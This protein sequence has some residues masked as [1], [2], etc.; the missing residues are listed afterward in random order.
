MRSAIFSLLLVCAACITVRP[1]DNH[2]WSQQYGARTS[3]LAGS[4]VAGV[5]DNSA[6]YYNPGAAG[7]IGGN[8]LSVNA[9]TYGYLHYTIDNGAGDGLN[10]KY[11]GIGFYPQLLSG[12]VRFKALPEWTFTYALIT[13]HQSTVN[14]NER[15]RTFTDVI[16]QSPGLEPYIAAYE[17]QDQVNEQWGGLGAAYQLSEY[18]S[19]GV[20]TFVSYRFE[21]YRFAK[22]ARAIPEDDIEAVVSTSNYD[23]LNFN[24]FNILWKAGLAFEYGRVRVGLA[25][26]TPSVNLYGT[27]EMQR[28]NSRYNLDLHLEAD[29]YYDQIA[30]DRQAGL[31]AEFKNPLS[32]AFGGEYVYEDASISCTIEYFAPV[33][34][35]KMVSAEPLPYLYPAEN[36]PPSDE[37]LSVSMNA[38]EV[39]NI[40][41]GAEQQ[42]AEDIT[43]LFGF[44]TDFD[45]YKN[46][47]ELEYPRMKYS[48]MDL[49]HFSSGFSVRYDEHFLTAG[50]TYTYGTKSGADQLVSFTR[51]LN[52]R[53]L[54]G[55][56]RENA[57]YTLHGIS[58]VLGYTYFFE[59]D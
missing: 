7:F 33:S 48:R 12:L 38:D 56:E 21:K 44:R 55:E 6:V 23:D 29:R 30:I 3:M 26:T 16:P 18:F 9:N 32:I 42:V 2:Y 36:P 37:F 41:I 20:T 35:Y 17:Y 4:V 47:E 28:E 5:R 27:A 11:Q 10:L 57:D 15:Y 59:E 8:S 54:Y 58:F 34:A 49:F 45:F 53:M 39:L 19:V 50:L 24:N 25:V 52:S 1:Q 43:V 13:R 14:F 40:A 22:Y 51:P 46:P 31:D